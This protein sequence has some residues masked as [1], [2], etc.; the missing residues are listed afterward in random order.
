MAAGYPY[1]FEILKRISKKQMTSSFLK[2][3]LSMMPGQVSLKDVRGRTLLHYACELNLEDCVKILVDFKS[4]V[5]YINNEN[6]KYLTPLGVAVKCRYSRLIKY[7]RAH[8]KDP[9]TNPIITAVEN[10][11]LKC[12]EELFKLNIQFHNYK[13]NYWSTRNLIVLASRIETKEIAVQMI[14]LLIKNGVT[15]SL[16]DFTHYD[17]S[18]SSK[19]ALFIALGFGFE[20][21]DLYKWNWW[22]LDDILKNYLKYFED[23]EKIFQDTLD[24][25]I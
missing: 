7:F 15:F 18:R 1:G 25:S 5:N 11:D 24:K 2:L 13:S 8:R 9:I 10:G 3:F 22:E 19:I 17:I 12:A 14:K 23:Y 4:D 21:N 6:S 16:K 20:E